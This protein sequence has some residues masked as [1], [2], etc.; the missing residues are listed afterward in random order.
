MI[1]CCSEWCVHFAKLITE[2][3]QFCILCCTYWAVFRLERLPRESEVSYVIVGPIFYNPISV[4]YN[5]EYRLNCD[6][7]PDK[8]RSNRLCEWTTS[9]N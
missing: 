9:R 2:R 5:M 7:T 3:V 6:I 4:C 8:L 1:S